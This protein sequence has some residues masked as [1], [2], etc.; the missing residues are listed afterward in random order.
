MLDLK[1]NLI[2]KLFISQCEEGSYKILEKSELISLLPQKYKVDEFELS[3]IAQNLE[4]ED[5]IS[6]KYEDEK[7]VC[8]CILSKALTIQ[9]TKEKYKEK[10]IASPYLFFLFVFFTT[11]LSS[12]ISCLIVKLLNI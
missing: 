8:L 9:E 7:V 6:I 5:Y 2:L 4:K 3:L 11:M 12:F 1:T 10:Q